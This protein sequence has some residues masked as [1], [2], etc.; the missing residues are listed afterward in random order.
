MYAA[1]RG[2]GARNLVIVSG[3]H[4][5]NLWPSTAPL[6]GTN[7]VYGVHAYTCP[8][9]PPP[10]CDNAAPYDP[11]QYFTDWSSAAQRV[12]I[13][14]TEFGWPNPKEGRYMTAV[15]Q[16]AAS[17]GWGWTAFAWANTSWGPFS[18]LA[19]AGPGRPYE[20]QPTGEALLADFPGR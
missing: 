17:R 7:L 14:V 16:Y 13:S 9:H 4:W 11:S 3:Q 18:L 19:N 20:P 10:N 8:L 1:V 15:V 12:P 6:A 5:G 2:T